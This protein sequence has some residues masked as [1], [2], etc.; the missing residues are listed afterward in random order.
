MGAL[1]VPKVGKYVNENFAAAF[2]KVATFRIVGAQK[3]GGNV[4]SY[5]C[6]P[7][8][9]VLHAIAGPVDADTYLREATWVVETTKAA[10]KVS[11][12]DGAKFKEYFRKA[13][14]QKL[15]DETG[16][17]VEAVTWD[18]PELGATD[19][20]T[21]SDPSGRP[22][23]PKLPPP[24]IDGPDVRLTADEFNARQ[25]KANAAPGARAIRCGVRGPRVV[26]NNQAV[27]H[28]ILAAHSLTKI[29]QVYGTVFEN[30]LGEKI[31]T[32][33]VDVVRP[34]SWVDRDG[35]RRAR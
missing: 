8:G 13:H 29:E 6:A 34:F 22:L 7:D 31:S 12:G 19:Q 21:Y 20:L 9:R 33:P 28:Q 5:F 11:A 15:R 23:A 4:A 10:M 35:Q 30:V 24:P 1:N 18:P 17:T 25:A 2:Q 26:V 16:L 27:M 3:Q 32:K 14:A